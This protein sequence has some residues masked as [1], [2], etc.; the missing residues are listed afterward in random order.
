V[1]MQCWCHC[2]VK[3]DVGLQY[4]CV[5]L[6]GSTFCDNQ[7]VN[8]HCVHSYRLPIS[9]IPVWTSGSLQRSGLTRTEKIFHHVP[10]ILVTCNK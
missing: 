3:F 6:S 4:S 7:F 2:N 10:C 8:M 1:L 5:P 9:N